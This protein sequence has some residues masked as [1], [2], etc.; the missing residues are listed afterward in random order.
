[1]E[2]QN[3]CIIWEVYTKALSDCCQS[4]IQ[5]INEVINMLGTNGKADGVRLDARLR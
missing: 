1:M 3:F 2:I 4:G 5:R